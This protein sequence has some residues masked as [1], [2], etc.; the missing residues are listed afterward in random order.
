MASKCI[1]RNE[2]NPWQFYILLLGGLNKAF[3]ENSVKI[4][5]CQAFSLL[6]TVPGSLATDFLSVEN[7]PIYPRMHKLGEFVNHKTTIVFRIAGH[8]QT[9]IE[10]S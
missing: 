6:K 3:R 1:V 4:S 5:D 9:K 2:T 8:F 10:Y 7:I